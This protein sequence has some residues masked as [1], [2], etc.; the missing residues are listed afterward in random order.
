MPISSIQHISLTPP[1]YPR[2]R[3]GVIEIAQQWYNPS[4]VRLNQD[5]IQSLPQGEVVAPPLGE[6]SLKMDRA[7]SLLNATEFAIAMGAINHMFWHHDENGQFV[8][9][10][11]KGMVGA[12][13]MSKSFENAWADPQSPIRLARD[14]GVPLTVSSIL[15]GFGNIPDPKGRMD[16]LNEILLS[17]Q[18]PRFAQKVEDFSL[19]GQEFNTTFSALLADAFPKGYADEV[20]KKAQLTTSVIWRVALG[21]GYNLPPCS[22]TAFADYQIPNVLRALGILE[23]NLDLA[24]HIDKGCL[25]QGSSAEERAIRSASILA[26]EELATSQG[27]GVADVDYW[28]W[29]KR[30]EAKTP[31][32]LTVT[33]AY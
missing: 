29:L 10:E 11:N 26:I 24:N 17:D 9:Y 28:V 32:H 15:D 7:S 3:T 6:V 22:L 16:I 1:A 27:V 23:Y 5:A 18:L 12:L 19:Q 31:F 2:N 33:T 14:Q 8:R 4:L 30:K 21:L 25:I 13:G 20:L